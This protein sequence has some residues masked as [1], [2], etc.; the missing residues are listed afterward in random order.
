MKPKQRKEPAKAAS[1]RVA[2]L[3]ATV[4]FGSVT[5]KV[6][7]P[8]AQVVKQNIEDG[9]AALV[10]AKTALLSRGVK[11]VRTKGKPLYFGSPDRPDVIIREVDGVR[12]VGTFSGGRFR[13]EKTTATKSSKSSSKASPKMAKC[14]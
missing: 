5:V 1:A 4:S 8:S 9:Q 7:S 11:I 3:E 2:G 10:R 14:A 6:K 12:T 13:I